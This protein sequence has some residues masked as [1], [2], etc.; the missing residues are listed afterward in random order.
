[1][2]SHPHSASPAPQT[3]AEPKLLLILSHMRSYSTLLSHILSSAGSIQGHIEQQRSYNST[4]E[5]DEFLESQ[6]TANTRF[7]CDNL[8]LNYLHVAPEVLSYER[9]R[10]LFSLRRPEATLA[11]LIRWGGTNNKFKDPENA[12]DYYEQRLG[13]IAWLAETATCPRMFFL[14]DRL[15]DDTDAALAD[16]AS[17]LSLDQLSETYEVYD[18]TGQPGKGDFSASIRTGSIQ[19]DRKRIPVE[20]PTGVL[21]RARSAYWEATDRIGAA[22]R[23]D[24]PNGFLLPGPRLLS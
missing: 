9:V 21:D 14:S 11:S 20:I 17:F 15:I 24:D 6:A 1:M 13:N 2:T 8:L 23:K 10:I 18:D 7:V 12:L 5:V 16:L 19:Q 3:A 22:I 4:K